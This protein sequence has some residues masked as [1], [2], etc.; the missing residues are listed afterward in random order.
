MIQEDAI[1]LAQEVS[2]GWWL[3]DEK[4]KRFADL[5]EAEFMNKLIA[6]PNICRQIIDAGMLSSNPAGFKARGLKTK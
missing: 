4:L 1:K 5:V 3:D 6:H 2:H